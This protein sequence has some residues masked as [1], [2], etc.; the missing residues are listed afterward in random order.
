MITLAE[1]YLAQNHGNWTAALFDLAAGFMRGNPTEMKAG[2]S[3]GNA[4]LAA[5]KVLGN[6]DAVSAAE[7]AEA[8]DVLER[9]A[10]PE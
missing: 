9:L 6:D 7:L 1:Q 5:A 4:L 10:N 8:V 2:Y 3:A